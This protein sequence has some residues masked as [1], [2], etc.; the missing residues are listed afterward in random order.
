M[1]SDKR[2]SAAVFSPNLSKHYCTSGFQVK[3]GCPP[4]NKN[5]KMTPLHIAKNGS[6]LKLRSLYCPGVG[7]EGNSSTPSP[8]VIK[9][10][11]CAS[12]QSIYLLLHNR[13]MSLVQ[14]LI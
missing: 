5:R 3:R 8:M 12:Y 11:L 14:G 10:S 4:P 9:P 2:P 1:S 13:F 6:C 7:G